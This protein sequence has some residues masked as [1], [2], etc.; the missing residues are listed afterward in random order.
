MMDTV[1]SDRR[2]TRR[3]EM[4]RRGRESD[5]EFGELPAS[6][7]GYVGRLVRMIGY[8]R[9]VRREVRREL[10]G[11]FADALTDC[12]S[13]EERQ[14]KAEQ[15]IVE[16][17]DPHLVAMLCRRA[18]KRCRP[19]WLK[20]IDAARMATFVL[21]LLLTLGWLG[22]STGESRISLEYIVRLNQITRPDIP[23]QGNAWPHYEA[24]LSLYVEPHD[25]DL[26]EIVEHG[27]LGESDG[28]LLSSLGSREQQAVKNWILQNEGAWQEFCTATRQAC[29]FRIYGCQPRTPTGRFPALWA[30]GTDCVNGLAGL[31]D[32]GIWRS[33]WAFQE[34]KWAEATEY[35]LAV[36]RAGS[37]WQS[38]AMLEEQLIGSWM[39]ELAHNEI[40]RMVQFGERTS[41]RYTDLQN[42]LVEIYHGGYPGLNVEGERLCVHDLIQRSFTEGGFGGGHIIPGRMKAII[43]HGL[44]DR[45]TWMTEVVLAFVDVAASMMHVRRDK[46]IGK[47]NELFEEIARCVQLRPYYRHANKGTGIDERYG[48]WD[49][50]RHTMAY[51]LLFD[52]RVDSERVFRGR[53]LHEAAVAIVA[54]KRYRR[55]TGEYPA[56]L[57]SLVDAAYIDHVPLDPYS[58]DS[59]VYRRVGDNFLLY[60]VGPDF[61]DDGGV[62]G[63]D[64]KGQR[65]AWPD[66]GD[67]VFWS[68]ASAVK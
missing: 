65:K 37:H 41:L 10:L 27:A 58:D 40:L 13:A 60:S 35:A 68:V 24:A 22:L 63:V 52:E 4:L 59:L 19:L 32:V 23:P 18:K 61:V 8:R 26:R 34:R 39:A 54:L 48:T 44:G 11:H 16:F 42:A 1:T 46:T 49:E 55:S 15:L 3:C 64:D 20:T 25:A 31:A 43:L 50:L 7:T 2:P 30:L 47:V 12:P 45:A 28:R 53:A 29:H 56:D 51:L 21:V 67:R 33:R 62:T 38:S 9:K 66:K 17:G 5:S 14:T 57:E 6:V 36:A